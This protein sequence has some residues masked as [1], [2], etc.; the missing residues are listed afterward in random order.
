VRAGSRQVIDVVAIVIENAFR[1][2]NGR[3]AVLSS[4]HR[5]IRVSQPIECVGVCLSSASQGRNLYGS[6]SWPNHRAR[7]SQITTEET[8]TCVEFCCALVLRTEPSTRTG[9][10]K[11]LLRFILFLLDANIAAPCS[12]T[13]KINSEDGSA[14]NGQTTASSNSSHCMKV[15]SAGTGLGEGVKDLSL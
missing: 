4:N 5:S 14:F 6:Q 10:V 7:R 8:V 2:A 9:S 11:C 3:S 13:K 1:P 15:I 12:S